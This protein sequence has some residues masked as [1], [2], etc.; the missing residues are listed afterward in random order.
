MK[1]VIEMDSGGVIYIR[2]FINIG[3]CGEELL[4]FCHSS[5]KGC[6]VGIIDGEGF[7]MMQLNWV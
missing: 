1:F 2:G 5:L 6:N 3:K 7:M 4:R